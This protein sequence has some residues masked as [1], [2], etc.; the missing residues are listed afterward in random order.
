MGRCVS[1][2]EN[3]NFYEGPNYWSGVWLDKTKLTLID[4]G[5]T[6]LTEADITFPLNKYNR[7]FWYIYYKK[8]YLFTVHIKHNYNAKHKEK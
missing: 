6:K 8:N 3:L 1:E 5:P 7:G 4:L 2:N